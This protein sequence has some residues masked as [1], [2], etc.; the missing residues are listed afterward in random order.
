MQIPESINSLATTRE[1]DPFAS[2][3][4]LP[5]LPL[6]DIITVFKRCLNTKELESF[7]T[8][9]VYFKKDTSSEKQI[10]KNLFNLYSEIF[11]SSI[12]NSSIDEEQKD[13]VIAQIKQFLD[14]LVNNFDSFYNTLFLLNKNNNLL[15][16]KCFL[17]IIIGYAITLIK[18]THSSTNQ[19]ANT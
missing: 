18:K 8:G 14:S 11:V 12:K 13:V 16:V 1:A 5:T 10:I 3:T 4:N 2:I 19:Q 15:D 6:D 9:L 7:N 17:L